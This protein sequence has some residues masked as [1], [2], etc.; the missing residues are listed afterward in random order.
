M[1]EDAKNALL[2]RNRVCGAGYKPPR[3]NCILY[4]NDVRDT[5]NELSRGNGVCGNKPY[6]PAE[7][8]FEN[9]NSVYVQKR[10]LPRKKHVAAEKYVYARNTVSVQEQYLRHRL[11]RLPKKPSAANPAFSF[12][13]RRKCRSI[14]QSSL[15]FARCASKYSKA[16]MMSK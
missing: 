3:R 5:E 8:M 12:C 13:K 10:C 6:R 16:S 14:I 11:L 7:T 9:E 1:D 15:P 2:C 4:E